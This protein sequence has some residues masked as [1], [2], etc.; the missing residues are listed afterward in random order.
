[1]SINSKYNQLK[2]FTNSDYYKK[3]AQTADILLEIRIEIIKF[4]KTNNLTQ[5]QL[6]QKMGVDQKQIHRMVSGNN[7]ISFPTLQKFCVATGARL[8]MKW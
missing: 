2:E 4:M 8:E 3:Y 5:D 7:N 6:A 1:M